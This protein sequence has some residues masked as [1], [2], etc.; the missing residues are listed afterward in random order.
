MDLIADGLLL[1]GAVTAAFY[2]W[3][4]SVRVKGLKDLDTGL[5][6]AIAALSHRVKDMQTTL[7]SAK[8]A[9]GEKMSDLEE[10]SKRAERATKD[11]K[12]LLAA[13]AAAKDQPKSSETAETQSA[14]IEK[15]PQ[16]NE[17]TPA[18]MPFSALDTFEAPEVAK[19]TSLPKLKEEQQV[20]PLAAKLANKTPAQTLRARVKD[21]IAN[22]EEPEHHDEL[23]RALQD[24]LAANK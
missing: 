19:P 20:T 10:L 9:T 14:Q 13:V 18:D 22:R 17:I 6:S 21:K 8:S 1:A 3:I 7:Q 16:R 11:L 12:K 15:F 4:L 24:I 5:G 23:V 2:C